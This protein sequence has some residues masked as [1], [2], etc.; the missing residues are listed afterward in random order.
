VRRVSVLAI[1]GCVGCT[2]PEFHF[3]PTDSAAVGDVSVMDSAVG[4]D[5][6][7]DS[8]APADSETPDTS[9]ADAADTATPV[10]VAPDAPVSRGC[11]GVLAKHCFDWDS[12]TTPQSGFTFYGVDAT[13]SIALDTTGG[14]SLPNAFLA[15]TSPGSTDVVT[16]NL[17]QQFTTA[18]NDTVIKMDAWIKLETDKFPGDGAFLLKIQRNGGS[19][20][21]ITFSIDATGF[22]VD[23][24]GLT[25]DYYPIGYKPK[26]GAWMHVRVHTKLHTALGSITAWIDDMVTPVV[27][28]SGVPTAKGDS[29]M[30]QAI[31][32]LY[33][34]KSTSTFKARYD[35]VVIDY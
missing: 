21:G 18:A 28:V 3:T 22:F 33:S 14:R 20:D 9:V 25:Y 27:N 6:A 10:D 35:D 4:V 31:V 19:G 2:Y 7:R 32:G 17:S 15:T 8:F 24:I 11:T 12:V 26:I 13:G 23:R 16:A 30:K 5:A 29:T 1:L 34:Q